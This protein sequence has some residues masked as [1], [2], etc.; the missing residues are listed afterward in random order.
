ML[1][2]LIKISLAYSPH[3]DSFIFR[4]FKL[5]CCCF[6]FQPTNV[7]RLRDL[8]KEPEHLHVLQLHRLY[9]GLSHFA[10]WIERGM[11]DGEDI[12]FHFVISFFFH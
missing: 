10:T 8:S 11:C 9:Y 2:F 1:L 5:I 6:S 12:Y 3:F 7:M 4:S